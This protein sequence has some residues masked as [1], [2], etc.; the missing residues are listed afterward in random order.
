MSQLAKARSA[1]YADL[2]ALPSNQVGQILMGTLHAHPRPTPR[3]ARA[4]TRMV[5]E[6][7]GPFDRG[8]GG[9]GGWIF[10]I[11]PELD[12]G[13][14]VVVPDIAGWRRDRL[15]R[16]PETPFIEIAPDWAC[17]VLSPSTVRIDRT[18]KLTIY[19]QFGVQHAWYVDPDART[20]EK[21]ELTGD[22]W[23]LAATY[24]DGDGVSAR[25]FEPHVFQLDALWPD[26]VCPGIDS[27][28]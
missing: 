8:R 21:L 26:D 27:S 15:R 13:P 7:D 4:A 6:L 19:G 28:D 16:L 3:H 23:L 17:E 2:E 5:S 9:P 24:K 22:K 12:L 10:L 1:V 25:P 11:E 20:L 18:D 14:H